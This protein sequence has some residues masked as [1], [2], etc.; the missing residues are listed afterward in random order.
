M[1]NEELINIMVERGWKQGKTEQGEE[2]F[3]RDNS[4]IWRITYPTGVSTRGS[5]WK[6]TS[7]EFDGSKTG[8]TS[9]VITPEDMIKL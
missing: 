4:T 3:K 7:D 9:M 2:E 1:D 6:F 5:Y 8:R